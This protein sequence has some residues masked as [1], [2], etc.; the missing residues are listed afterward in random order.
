[1]HLIRAKYNTIF[2]KNKIFPQILNI[3]LLAFPSKALVFF[4]KN[5]I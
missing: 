4:K 2:K 5:L 1:M 3:Y